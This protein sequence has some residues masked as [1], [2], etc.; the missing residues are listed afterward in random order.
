MRT[1]KT[2]KIIT[3]M[4]KNTFTFGL[5]SI[6]L[7]MIFVFMAC[8]QEDET[9]QNL[10]PSAKPSFFATKVALSEY[11]KALFEYAEKLVPDSVEH[12]WSRNYGNPEFEKSRVLRDDE[13]TAFLI[14]VAK[15]NSSQY[16]A[17]LAI[18]SNKEKLSVRLFPN[19]ELIANEEH[20][21]FIHYAEFQKE[22]GVLK[23]QKYIFREQEK[24]T[25]TLM[26]IEVERIEYT[27]CRSMFVSA[28][29]GEEYYK[30]MTCKDEVMYVLRSARVD[31]DFVGGDSGGYTGSYG[32]GGGGGGLPNP[33]LEVDDKEIEDTKVECVKEKLEK[34]GDASLVNQLLKG[35]KLEES[36][37]NVI[38]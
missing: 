19:E 21:L 17:L 34:G 10:E 5:W 6:L 1:T 16:N 28:G 9:T 26:R 31:P 8:E 3:N 35:F 37:I 33:D 20:P 38:Y 18:Y 4:K 14:P 15:E 29:G 32:G 25:P 36:K 22:K 12:K 13:Q 24:V 23:F 11:E 2:L 27:T 30:R 7:L